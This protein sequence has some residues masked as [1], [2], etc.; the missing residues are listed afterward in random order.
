[1]SWLDGDLSGLFLPRDLEVLRDTASAALSRGEDLA[2]LYGALADQEPLAL[3]DLVLGPKALGALDAALSV[4][5]TVEASSN[6][7]AVFRRLGDLAPDRRGE[8]L[9]LACARHPAAG[10]LATIADWDETPGLTHLRA[11]EGHPAFAN[12]CAAYAAAGHTAALVEVAHPEALAALASKGHDEAFLEGAAR[13]LEADPACPIVPF[14]CAARGPA[15][16]SLI[17]RVLPRLRSRAAAENLQRDLAPF[18]EEQKLLALLS[19]GM[20]D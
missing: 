16:R 14:A 5:D 15:A 12:V 20:R 13:A 1:M 7:A 18:P 3:A 6:P 19:A 2:P 10:W 11:A 17:R 8:L 4:I 9:A